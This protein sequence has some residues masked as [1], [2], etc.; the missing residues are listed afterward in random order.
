MKVVR[1]AKMKIL[2]EV[3]KVIKGLIALIGWS[4]SLILKS[5]TRL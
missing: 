5:M 3:Q 2:V 4:H 1:V